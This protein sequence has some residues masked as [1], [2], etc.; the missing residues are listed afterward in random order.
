MLTDPGYRSSLYHVDDYARNMMSWG[1]V[2]AGTLSSVCLCRAF[3][4]R[5]SILVGCF[6]VLAG[7]TLQ[8]SAQHSAQLLLGCFLVSMALGLLSHSTMLQDAELSPP[9]ARGAILVLCIDLAYD[10]GTLLGAGVVY[11]VEAAFVP[12]WMWR[13][14]LGGSVLQAFALVCIVPFITETPASLVQRGR[15]DE[16]LHALRELRGPL[17]SEAALSEEFG[18]LLLAAGGGEELRSASSVSFLFCF[19]FVVLGRMVWRKRTTSHTTQTNKNTQNA[20]LRLLL[21]ELR[22]ALRPEQAPLLILMALLALLAVFMRVF[23]VTCVRVF[24]ERLRA[25]THEAQSSQTQTN[26]NTRN[27]RPSRRPSCA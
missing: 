14:V 21:R 7:T 6:L 16:G 15:L 11:A 17:V 27:R 12:P 1:A 22:N 10:V 4:R 8:C 13:L 2:V 25:N 18:Q 24:F 9:S 26:T 20:Q 23:F 5:N 19:L 3:G